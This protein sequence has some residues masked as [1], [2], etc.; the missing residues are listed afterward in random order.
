M[1]CTSCLKNSDFIAYVYNMETGISMFLCEPCH[2][3]GETLPDFDI[4]DAPDE[5]LEFNLTLF[6]DT[7]NE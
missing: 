1:S 5:I 4:P 6:E 7:A 3:A 2:D